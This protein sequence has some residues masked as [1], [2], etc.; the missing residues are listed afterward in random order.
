[1]LFNASK[2]FHLSENETK[3]SYNRLNKY[4]LAVKHSL[5]AIQFMEKQR[6]QPNDIDDPMDIDQP[7]KPKLFLQSAY[8]LLGTI[9]FTKSLDSKASR[10]QDFTLAHQY[11]QRE[12]EIIDTMTAEDIDEEQG[13]LQILSQSSYFNMGVME[14]KMPWMHEDAESNLKRAL[15]L[16]MD[17]R[18][19]VSEKTAWWELG[20]LY[21]RTGQ[22]DLV[23]GCQQKEF[24]L[25]KL[26][27]FTD[28][29]MFCVQERSESL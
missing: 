12:R 7:I 20:N 29:L 17:L 14:A 25:I 18:D 19:H 5:L 15:A 16:A 3:S 8:K 22:F 13:S 28:D 4:E 10:Y 9:Y 23:K 1:M 11:Y 26:Y 2:N 6:D 24:E 27:E 21:K